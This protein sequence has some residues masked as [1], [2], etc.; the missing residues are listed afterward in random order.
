M[1]KP[2]EID[3]L[4]MVHVARDIAK[5]IENDIEYPVQIKVNIIR[6][7]RAVEYAK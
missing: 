2:N 3:D 7:K 5:Q 4:K 1:D 6:E